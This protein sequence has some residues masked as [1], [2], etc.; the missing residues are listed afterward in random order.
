MSAFKFG[1]FKPLAPGSSFRLWSPADPPVGSTSATV[2]SRSSPAVPKPRSK[3]PK[4]H[5]ISMKARKILQSKLLFIS[6]FWTRRHAFRRAGRH[7][8][9]A[10]RAHI[11][12]LHSVFRH[13][14]RAPDEGRA[15]RADDRN[16][17]M[18]AF[19]FFDITSYIYMLPLSRPYRARKLQGQKCPTM[20][21]AQ[22]Q[23]EGARRRAGR[24]ESKP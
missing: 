15:R 8:S 3:V 2:A 1:K 13:T 22:V 10:R 11:P 21:L 24:G 6:R 23:R 17:R 18:F 9:V 5:R 16:P 7:P 20:V 19:A 12:A 14:H 4:L